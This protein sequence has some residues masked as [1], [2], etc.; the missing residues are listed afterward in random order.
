[1]ASNV[2]AAANYIIAG[3]VIWAIA[4]PAALCNLLGNYFGSAYAIKNGA[5][6]IKKMLI[7]V[8]VGVFIKLV[9][10]II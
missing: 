1:M 9:G 3:K 8:L 10:D 5:K 4:L 6:V 2:A 7:V